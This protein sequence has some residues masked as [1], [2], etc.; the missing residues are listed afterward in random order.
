MCRANAKW[1]TRRR[2]LLVLA[3]TGIAAAA[4]LFGGALSSGAHADPLAVLRANAAPASPDTEVIAK[5][6]QGLSTGNTGA[7]LRRL[8]H[9][10]ASRPNDADTLAA[11]GLAYQQRG[12]ETGDPAYYRLSGEALHRSA[13]ARGPLPVIA[14]GEASLANTRHRFRDGLRLAREAIGLDPYN[15]SAY[16]ALGDALL[17]LGRY[18]EAFKVYDKMAVLAPGIASF[19]RVAAARELIGRPNAAAAA[20][21]L[22]LEAD[23]T[24]PENVAWTMTQIGNTRFNTGRLAAAATAYRRALARFPGY[25]HADAGLARVE[26][27]EGRYREAVARLR[28]VVA[29]LPIPAY[30]IMLGDILRASGRKGEAR[31]EYALVGAIEKLFAANGVRTELQ[32]AVFDLD[33]GRNVADALARARTAYAS[34]PG[35]YAEDAL[36]WGLYRTGRCEAARPHSVRA[37]R[38]GTRDALLVFHRAMIEQ[39][40]GSA[41]SRAWFRRALAINPHFSFLWAPVA[42]AAVRG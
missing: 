28:G 17:N 2:L 40:L 19:T 13:A 30:V 23:Q 5:L 35:V 14:Q 4:L 9:R 16:G 22:A 20:D 10:V 25:V 27:A 15:G 31:R 8:E 41:S 1:M 36:A 33:H 32:T 3:G 12:R 11:L 6:L 34:A 39:C 21:E 26:A 29:R 38:L 37:L 7:L 18:R 42:R 24:V